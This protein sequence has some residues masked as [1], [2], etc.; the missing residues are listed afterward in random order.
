[1]RVCGKFLAAARI[2]PS[3]YLRRGQS[4]AGTSAGAAAQAFDASTA[5]YRN[6]DA[7]ERPAEM[8]INFIKISLLI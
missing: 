8:L 6:R 5:V 1:M 7:C 4:D 2:M 3:A